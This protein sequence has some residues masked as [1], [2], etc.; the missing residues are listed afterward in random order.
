MIKSPV[1]FVFTSYRFEMKN[2]QTIKL[3]LK[4]IS[5]NHYTLGTRYIREVESMRRASGLVFT[6][7]YY[8]AV[9]LH[10]TRYISGSKLKTNSSFVSLTKDSFPT[11]VLYLKEL[12]DS[13]NLNNLRFVFTLLVYT[14]SIIPTKEEIEKV[15]PS[16]N[17]ITDPY[18]G[19]KGNIIPDYIID[20]FVTKYNLVQRSKF[21]FD[22]D[23]HYLSNKS[24]PFGKSTLTGPF[25]LFSSIFTYQKLLE[26]FLKVMGERNY[27]SLIGN[28]IKLLYKDHKLMHPGKVN[29]GQFGK[30]SIV[31]DPELKLR[32]IAMLDYYSQLVLKKVHNEIFALLRRIPQDRTFTQDPTFQ[33]KT[34]GHKF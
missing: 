18:K 11:R 33:G 24:S 29:Q 16:Y 15:K 19:R 27:M 17:S 32:P 34:L 7:A 5:P 22:S 8:K 12:C 25:G 28:Y 14:R 31:K 21:T 6:I 26:I 30:I 10:I 13:K 2:I 23:D 3:L 4:S 1:E 9:K 20:E